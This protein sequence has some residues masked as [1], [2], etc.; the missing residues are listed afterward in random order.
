MKSFN[1]GS[2]TPQTLV[3]AETGGKTGFGKY[4]T[5]CN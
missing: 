1:D 2:T 4:L 5:D 3:R